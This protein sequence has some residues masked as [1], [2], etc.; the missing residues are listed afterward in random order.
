MRISWSYNPKFK[1]MLKTLQTAYDLH[2]L[3]LYP[4]IYTDKFLTNILSAV[5]KRVYLDLDK[6]KWIRFY[7]YLNEFFCYSSGKIS[8]VSRKFLTVRNF[9][10]KFS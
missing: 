8:D 1:R 2:T 9:Q 5:D 10:K 4:I 6:F 3:L 7:F